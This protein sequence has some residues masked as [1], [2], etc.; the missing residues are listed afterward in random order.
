ML[1]TTDLVTAPGTSAA[2]ELQKLFPNAKVIKA[3]NTTFAE[4]FSSTSN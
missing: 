1:L 3:F 4:D 2:E